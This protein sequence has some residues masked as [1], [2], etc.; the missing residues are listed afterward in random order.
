MKK[1]GKRNKSAFFARVQK[2]AKAWLKRARQYEK[3]TGM[4]YAV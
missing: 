1:A 3:K 4:V 2:K